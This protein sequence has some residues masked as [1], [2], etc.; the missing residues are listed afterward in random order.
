MSSPRFSR[1]EFEA[2][3]KGGAT[4]GSVVED[5]Q[6]HGSRVVT[7]PVTLHVPL[8]KPGETDLILR[9]NLRRPERVHI[10]YR[11]RKKCIV[12]LDTH[13][14]HRQHG[15]L[16]LGS[17]M[18]FIS[19]PLDETGI[20]AHPLKPPIQGFSDSPGSGDRVRYWIPLEWMCDRLSISRPTLNRQDLEEVLP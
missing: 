10:I 7:W 19:D 5:V 3:I 1:G 14:E 6:R 12:R 13:D 20:V 16:F 18:H 4:L 2:C 11:L 9:Y 8:S 15:K 17:H